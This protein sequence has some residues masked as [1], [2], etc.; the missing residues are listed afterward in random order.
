[1]LQVFGA[2][3][4]NSALLSAFHSPLNWIIQ[5]ARLVVAP[6]AHKAVL[7]VLDTAVE[8]SLDMYHAGA[9]VHQYAKFGM[10]RGDFEEAFMGMEQA[11]EN[12]RSLG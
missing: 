12:Y 3:A 2:W 8:R 9:Y 7:G 11:V 10:E 4:N 1:M 5:T 6:L